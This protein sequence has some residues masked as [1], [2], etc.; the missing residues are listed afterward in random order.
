MG[1]THLAKL[2]TQQP[3]ESFVKRTPST[4]LRNEKVPKDKIKHMSDYLEDVSQQ[5]SADDGRSYHI[6]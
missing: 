2:A 4:E 6:R 5:P 1:Y 3:D